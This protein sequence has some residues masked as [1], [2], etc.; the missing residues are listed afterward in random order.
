MKFISHL[1]VMRYFQKVIKRADI[2]IAYSAG[3]NPH[4]IMSFASP[5]GLGHTSEAEYV[6]IEVHSTLKTNEALNILNKVSVPDMEILSYKLL[7]DGATKAMTLVGAAEY[8]VK[9]REGYVPDFNLDNAINDFMS[10]DSIVVT[11]ETKK[12]TKE[13]NLIPLI[14]E[15]RKEADG[16]FIKLAAGSV[17]NLK[18]ELVFSTIYDINNSILPEFALML[19]RREI[20]G[21]DENG[22]LKSLESFGD[23]I[24]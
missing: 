17:D 18:P 5:L 15:F 23:D 11:K 1:D 20:Y 19:E 12:G 16:Y 7:P 8:F 9:I 21:Y 14:Y 3:F 10:K 13:V 22:I 4:Q 2:D 6:D 24:V